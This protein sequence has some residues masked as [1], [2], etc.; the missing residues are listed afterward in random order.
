M[1]KIRKENQPSQSVPSLN[2]AQY[3]NG[4]DHTSSRKMRTNL[5][6]A[7]RETEVT[8]DWLTRLYIQVVEIN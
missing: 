3:R 5:S 8:E 7:H 1:S 2:R 6:H 4:N